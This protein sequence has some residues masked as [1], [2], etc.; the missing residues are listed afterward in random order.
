[1]KDARNYFKDVIQADNP[2]RFIKQIQPHLAFVGKKVRVY[3]YDNISYNATLIGITPNGSL[4][5]FTGKETK[6]IRSGSINPLFC[7]FP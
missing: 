5:L 3:G 4:E 1:M 7:D 2:S 6:I